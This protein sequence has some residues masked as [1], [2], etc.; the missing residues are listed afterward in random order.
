MLR[1][2]P[3]LVAGLLWHFSLNAQTFTAAP[4]LPVTVGTTLI[5]ALEV[6]GLP[7]SIGSE[8]FG[9]EA[10]CLSLSYPEIKHLIVTLYAPDGTMVKL[11]HLNGRDDADHLANTC[12]GEAGKYFPW[13]YPPYYGGYQPVLPLGVVNN[14]QNPNGAW[15]LV[16][17]EYQSDDDE[18]GYLERW[19]LTFGKHPARRTF[20]E[21]SHLPVLVINT[22][23]QVIPDEPKITAHLGVIDNP[24]GMANRFDGDFNAY[25][26]PIGIE[27][28]GAS[29]KS[30]WQPS[31]SLE[32]R[33]TYGEDLDVPLLGLPAESDWVLHGPFTDKSLFRN[34]LTYALAREAF[35]GYVPRTRFCEVVLDGSY[36]G[37]YTLVEKIKRGA[38]R[39]D[40]AKLKKSDTSGDALTGGYIV[41]ID[42]RDADGWY[43][44]FRS[45]PPGSG[46][47]V[48][49]NYVYPKAEDIQPEQKAYI[50]AYIDSF[51]VALQQPGFMDPSTGWRR[52]ADEAS[53]MDYF[54]FNEISKNVDAY[55]LSAYLYKEKDS[56]GGKLHAG[57]LWDFNLAWRNANYAFNEYPDGWSFDSMPRG[58]PLWWKRMLQDSLFAQ[59]LNCR[60][61]ELRQ[62]TFSQRHIF[63][64]ID[65]LAAAL[66]EATGRH[67]GLYPI[68]GHGIWPNPK[69]I[70]KT[71][72]EEIANMKYWISARLHWMDAT[73]PGAC[74]ARP[75][76]YS[77]APWLVYPNP[78]PQQLSV[79]F[80]SA[81]EEESALELT[82]I[83]GRVLDRRE[84]S[85]FE[86]T[87]DVS[88]L[89]DGMYL[90][91]YRG[92]GGRM[93]R[94]EKVV[95]G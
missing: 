23:G 62:S 41:K 76:P 27:W 46:S 18:A 36:T 47:K 34:A 5:S 10:V 17:Q 19:S 15:R 66:G 56:D 65:S 33:D 82:D 9:L 49:F 2:L 85:G 86:T 7:D 13:E 52:F 16:V 26:G 81:P 68:L 3:C 38:N 20:P 61:S 73:L 67:F 45:E 90:L 92:K 22:G 50:Q 44:Q 84:N 12:F 48:Y 31:F 11:I 42:R 39:L 89:A 24:P 79:F 87:F 14:G 63:Q 8:H 91:V 1:T 64:V 83:A 43:S 51:E 40:I 55:R 72:G 37:V 21:N 57:P 70:A 25:N 32:T 93:L 30:F 75:G 58:V 71:H 77:P 60:W 80:E 88:A 95:K 78:A 94:C 54:L 35:P 6:D 53:F 29:S 28:R 74:G 59:N 4:V 69:P